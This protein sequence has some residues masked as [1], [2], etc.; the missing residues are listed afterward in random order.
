MQPNGG[1]SRL[2]PIT[3][4]GD[5]PDDRDPNDDPSSYADVTTPLTWRW[6]W[7]NWCRQPLGQTRV[8]IEA[9]GTGKSAT[10]RPPPPGNTVNCR[11]VGRDAPWRIS[12]WP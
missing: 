7:R 6:A 11:G 1:R 5:L 8:R 10:V 12:P 2:S 4:E 9:V 3:I